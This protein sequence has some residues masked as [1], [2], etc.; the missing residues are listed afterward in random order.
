MSNFTIIT[1]QG[2]ASGGELNLILLLGIAVFAGT[3]G[4]KLFQ[5]LKIPQIV[6]Y[7]TIGIIL[8]PVA[9]VIKPQSVETLETFNLF[10]LGIIGFLIGGEL[11]RE[12]F[13]K[14]G[15]QVM[16]ILLFEGMAAFFLVGCVSFGIMM[17]FKDWQTSLAVAV[18]F[19]AI[20]SAT[21]PASTINVLWEYK[22]RGPVTTMVTAIVAL[23]DALALVLYAGI[24]F[25]FPDC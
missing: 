24:L 7:V 14:F 3:I 17:L 13:V 22:T 21:D 15:R 11:K 5:K 1:A 25:V 19:A 9:G 20:C 16:T 18:V 6:G 23:D 10:A 2:H 4:A 12:I 8:G